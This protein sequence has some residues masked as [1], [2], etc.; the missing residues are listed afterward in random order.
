[1][2]FLDAKELYDIAELKEENESTLHDAVKIYQHVID[3]Y[4]Y[5]IYSTKASKA[6]VRIEKKHGLNSKAV[7]SIYTPGT[8]YITYNFELSPENTDKLFVAPI[9]IFALIGPFF[10]G[11]LLSLSPFVI[12]V[13][14]IG[15]VPATIA[16][17][18][19]SLSLYVSIRKKNKLPRHNMFR[20][21]ISGFITMSV[22]ALLGALKS[23]QEHISQLW[24][25]LV[26]SGSIG[27]LVSGGL[28]GAYLAKKLKPRKLLHIR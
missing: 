12:F 28:T 10:G 2:N 23:N 14:L 15:I 4:D 11:Y 24:L 27:G 20:G 16:G 8:E 22:I 21:F 9:M 1:V 25:L 5:S 3:E 17:L 18:I 6:L 7:D 19:F 13:Y 26:A